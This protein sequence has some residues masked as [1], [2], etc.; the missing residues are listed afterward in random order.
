MG[1][2]IHVIK[3]NG[4]HE[5]RRGNNTSDSYNLSSQVEEPFSRLEDAVSHMVNWQAKNHYGVFDDLSHPEA[6]KWHE[7]DTRESATQGWTKYLKGV[8]KNTGKGR[9]I[10]LDAYVKTV[11]RVTDPSV[12][13]AVFL[14]GDKEVGILRDVGDYLMHEREITVS[15]RDIPQINSV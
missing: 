3:R 2:E 9:Y 8:A 7:P 13:R 1:V 4:K 11:Q 15:E 10:D 5:Y 6:S 12:A 14:L